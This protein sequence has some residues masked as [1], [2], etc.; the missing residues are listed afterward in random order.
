MSGGT[1]CHSQCAHWLRND[2]VR[3]AVQG[4]AGG[5]SRPPLRMGCKGCLRG[6][7]M[8][9]SAPTN[10]CLCIS[11]AAVLIFFA[12]AAGVRIATA[13]VRTGFA[14]TG[15]RRDGIFYA[16]RPQ[17]FLYFLP[18]P[19]GQGSFRPIFCTRRGCFFTVPSPPTLSPVALATRSRLISS[20]FL[21]RTE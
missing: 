7:P 10:Y 2:R 14:M 8:P 1:D 3:N 15:Y 11:A 12:G 6:G 19:Q 16:F 5:Q 9:T 17:Q 20:S 13:S 18:E 21:M 4:P